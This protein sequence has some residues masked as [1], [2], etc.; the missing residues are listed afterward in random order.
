MHTVLNRQ[1]ELMGTF[2]SLFSYVITLHI[3]IM[4]KTRLGQTTTSISGSAHPADI[5][6]TIRSATRA[7]VRQELRRQMIETCDDPR[8]DF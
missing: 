5:E 4:N 3:R 2:G 8:V 1:P 6:E 7:Q